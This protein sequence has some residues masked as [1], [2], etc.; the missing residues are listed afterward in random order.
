MGGDLFIAKINR[1]EFDEPLEFD[2]PNFV[3]ELANLFESIR[4]C[5][6]KVCDSDYEVYR[7]DLTMLKRAIEND[8]CYYEAYKK[9]IES[10]IEKMGITMDDFL[11]LL[12]SLITESDQENYWIRFGGLF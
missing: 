12:E 4:I 3:T 11:G 5:C 8:G 1:L 6:S 9:E 7:P 10:F 2:N